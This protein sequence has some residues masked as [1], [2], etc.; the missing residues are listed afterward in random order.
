MVNQVDA[1]VGCRPYTLL[2]E[3]DV[4]E[5]DVTSYQLAYVHLLDELVGGF[6]IDVDAALIVKGIQLHSAIGSFV[7][8][9]LDISSAVSTVYTLLAEWVMGNGDAVVAFHTIFGSPPYRP[10]IALTN[11][12][13]TLAVHSL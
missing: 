4:V 11:V 5:R 10:V 9:E 7:D 1:I 2:R 13:D 12:V 8:P 3:E 6:V